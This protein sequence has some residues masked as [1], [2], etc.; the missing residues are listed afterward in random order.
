MLTNGFPGWCVLDGDNCLQVSLMF[1][2]R[3]WGEAP[4]CIRS[5]SA[6]SQYDLPRLKLRLNRVWCQSVICRPKVKANIDRSTV[7][8]KNGSR[9]LTFRERT[10]DR[11]IL[12]LDRLVG[13]LCVIAPIFYQAQF[14]WTS[15]NL[16]FLGLGQGFLPP[17]HYYTGLRS[18]ELVS[19]LQCISC[20]FI[21]HGSRLGR[22]PE[23]LVAVSTTLLTVIS[24]SD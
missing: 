4:T 8:Q 20:C 11:F 17:P 2:H 22:S 23:V 18:S 19:V 13:V 3:P 6:V 10:A 9:I 7:R 12:F 24:L 5:L 21:V 15:S 16:A 14:N 1:Y